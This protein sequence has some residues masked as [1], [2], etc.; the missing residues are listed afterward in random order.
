MRLFSRFV[1]FPFV[2]ACAG[3]FVSSSIVLSVR[4]DMANIHE[5]NLH[6]L[7][8]FT[9]TSPHHQGVISAS[10]LCTSYPLQAHGEGQHMET[11]ALTTGNSA[12]VFFVNNLCQIQ[13]RFHFISFLL[14]WW[15]LYVQCV[16]VFLG[17]SCVNP[18]WRQVPKTWPATGF[19]RLVWKTAQLSKKS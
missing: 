14:Y 4:K 5:R 19:T 9:L 3:S 11:S 17:L 15:V 7:W 2:R 6:L 16:V 18:H 1:T 12:T 10:P 8:P 13:K